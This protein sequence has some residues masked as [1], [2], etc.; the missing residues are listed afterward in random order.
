MDSEIQIKNIC[1]AAQRASRAAARADSARKDDF[2]RK[3]ASLLDER[4]DGLLAA[5]LRD[6]ERAEREGMDRPRL[7][8]LALAP[9]IIDEMRRACLELADAPDPIGATESQWQRPNGLLVGKMRIP[10]GV[11]AMIYEARPNVTTDAAI[12][13]VK[14][15]NAVILRGGR[16]AMDSNRF[17]ISLVREA[18]RSAGLPEDIAQ[19]VWEGGHEAVRAL[20]RQS[21][22]VD[23][24]IPRGGENLIKAVADCATVPVL[25]HYKG[26]CHAYIDEDADVEQACS[27]VINSKAQRPGVCNALECL[28]VN[29]KIAPTF[30][31]ILAEKLAPYK[32]E[33]RACPRSLPFSGAN[34]RPLEDDD[35][36]KE[37]HALIMSVVAVD[38]LEQAIN[39]IDRYGSRHTDIICTS[40]YGNAMRF[41]REV[42]SS[43]VAVNA[44]TRFNDGGQLGLGAEIGISTSRLHAFGPMGV[45]EL[46]ATKF[47][48][49]GSGQIRT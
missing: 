37:F 16:E 38:S 30:L 29:S 19:L 3:L 23:L 36:G 24:V 12:I 17:L 4:V 15:G 20:C 46:T 32:V 5:N 31:P 7:D 34:A 22:L 41:L 10:I 6:M 48:A 45:K 2:L 9:K 1:E 33:L 8:R 43:L 40:N 28:L 49:L 25:M 13:C 42:D 14:A 35:L 27:I 21:G 44:S 39:H 18:L 26:V 47:V 11:V